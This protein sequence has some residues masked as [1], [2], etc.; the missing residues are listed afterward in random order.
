MQNN[1][2]EIPCH[3]TDDNKI[4]TRENLYE[5]T[6]LNDKEKSMTSDQETQIYFSL[7]NAKDMNLGNYIIKIEPSTSTPTVNKPE[8]NIATNESSSP[9]QQPS[10][11][12]TRSKSNTVT[13][14]PPITIQ[15]VPTQTDENIVDN[16]NE[17]NGEDFTPHFSSDD[18]CEMDNNLPKK[19][20]RGRPRGVRKKGA[21]IRQHADSHRKLPTKFKTAKNSMKLD[22]NVE[23]GECFV[24]EEE[25]I[26]DQQN[27]NNHVDED[28]IVGDFEEFDVN[29]GNANEM[30]DEGDSENEFPARDSD[31]DDWPAQQTLNKFPER[32]IQNGVLTVKGKKL[33][34]MISK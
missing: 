6:N 20:G 16:Q 24:K 25:D 27:I 7:V 34:A 21:N 2:E 15:S 9:T 23:R 31:N 3:A 8:T 26:I 28:E 19:Q 22:D 29:N 10:T 30:N 5:S 14:I 18:D 32:I 1:L 13:Q 17:N 11:Y 4:E 33:K 12:M